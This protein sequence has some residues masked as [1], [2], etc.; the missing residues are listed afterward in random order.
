LP[1]PASDITLRGVFT[2]L[3]SGEFI[4][5]STG[6][7]RIVISEKS[8]RTATGL[9]LVLSATSS[10]RK[11]LPRIGG[12]SRQ[13]MNANGKLGAVPSLTCCTARADLA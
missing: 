12:E 5:E 10:E 6:Y 3:E 7:L 8:L 11:T 13:Q 1:R 9:V 2:A 4:A